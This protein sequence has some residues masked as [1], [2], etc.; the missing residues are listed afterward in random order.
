[1]AI[2]IKVKKAEGDY[3]L[4]ASKFF[5]EPTVP[6]GWEGEF[7]DDEI[8]FCQIRLAD[9]AHLDKDNRLPHTGYLYVFLDTE[10]GDYDLVADV[11][12]FDG[13]PELV[14]DGFNLDVA[15]YERFNNAYL[16][17]F[18]EVD[19]DDACTRLFGNPSDWNYDDT[20]PKMLLQYDPLDNET[21]FLDFLDG[22]LYFFYGDDDDLEEVWLQEEFS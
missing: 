8:F 14:L 19:D 9:I 1:M 5:G 11:K 2:G 17:E 6:L 7:Y 12:Y 20:P 18:V 22:F 3:D 4:L 16:M 10:G 13:E 15:G 21:G